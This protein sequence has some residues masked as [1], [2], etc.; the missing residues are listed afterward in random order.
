MTIAAA[1]ARVVNRSR[2]RPR[3]R[4]GSGLRPAAFR[5]RP[6][7]AAPV[8]RRAARRRPR[9]TPATRARLAAAAASVSGG[10]RVTDANGRAAAAS[11]IAAM[12]A[13][14]SQA[15]RATRVGSGGGSPASASQPATI[16][17]TPAAMAGGTS[18]TTSRLTAGA[19]IARRPNTSSTT[20]S[21]A[22]CAASETPRL[23]ASQSGTRPGARSRMRVARGVPQ[24]MRPPVARADSSSPG[25]VTRCGSRTRR[26]ATAQPRA[27]A[28]LPLRPVSRASRTTPA[29]RAAR[30]TDGDAP[31]K[32]VYATTA[33]AVASARRR[34]D[35]RRIRAATTP[36]TIAMFQPEMATTWLTPA[37]VKAA[38][39]AR[40]T[41]S[42]NPTRMPAASPASG[43]GRTRARP[44]PVA[45]RR[46]SSAPPGPLGPPST[47]IVNG[48]IVALAPI[49]RRYVPKAL[50]GGGRSPPVRVSRVPG[51]TSG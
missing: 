29:M 35:R 21:V 7:P 43:S 12:S 36:A 39:R 8:A 25:S 49:R 40:S 41:R 11:T 48:S 3:A 51:A 27:A 50:S 42:R 9:A 20:G 38:A 19:T 14:R 10:S 33:A 44:S 23:S 16:A 5:G 45:R 13:R 37:A 1:H 22:T 34:R 24:A 15:G 30:T 46:L 6:E 28:A 4:A 47:D 31:A 32:T 26:I 17:A 2:P 18:G